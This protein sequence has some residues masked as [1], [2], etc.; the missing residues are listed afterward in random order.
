MTNSSD[1]FTNLELRIYEFFLT[2]ICWFPNQLTYWEK[3]LFVTKKMF[4]FFFNCSTWEKF[5]KKI[6]CYKLVKRSDEFVRNDKVSKRVQ[7]VKIKWGTNPWSLSFNTETLRIKTLPTMSKPFQKLPD[8]W[9][10]KFRSRQIG[11][12]L[13]ALV[14]LKASWTDVLPSE[15][16]RLSAKAM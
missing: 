12:E 2:K 3:K 9:P 4:G 16:Q 5:V 1:G 7:N 13:L 6:S 15:M 8:Q 11:H 14:A 10:A